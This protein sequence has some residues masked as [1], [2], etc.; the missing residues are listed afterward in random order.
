MS[1]ADCKIYVSKFKNAFAT[2][3]DPF[4]ATLEE[5]AEIIRTTGAASKSQ[6]PWLKLAVFGGQKTDKGSLR[7]DANILEITGIELDY[8]GEQMA[9]DDIIGQLTALGLASL[10]YTSPSHTPGT[11]RWRILCP[12]SASLPPHQRKLL[13]ARLNGR[14][15]GILEG[16]PE[17]F[18][19]SQ[20]YYYGR[21]LDNLRADHKVEVLHGD[22]IDLRED[23]REFETAGMPKETVEE[24]ERV[25]PQLEDDDEPEE[26]RH[27]VFRG[28]FDFI[29]DKMGDGEGLNGFNAPLRAAIAHYVGAFSSFGFDQVMRE[30]LK[31]LLRMK[32]VAAPK[33]ANRPMAEIVD[34]MSD[35]SLD[36]DIS[37]F[38]RVRMKKDITVFDFVANL[39]S[40]KYIYEPTGEE[41]PRISVDFRLK[42][43]PLVD[44]DGRLSYRKN[45]KIKCVKSSTWLQAYRKIE[46]LSWWP[47][48]PKIMKNLWLTQ[49]G[50][51]VEK[52]GH[53]CYNLYLAPAECKGDV[54]KAK[55]WI[56]HVHHIFPDD[57][58]IILDWF[59]HRFQKP[60]EKINFALLLGSIS[61]IG[62]D[63]IIT[64]AGNGLGAGNF[65]TI[66]PRVVI[67]SRFTGYYRSVLLCINEIFDVGEGNR[68]KF[69]EMM[70]QLCASP[71]ETLQVNL[72]MKQEF[73]VR[74]CCGVVMTTNH[75]EGIYLPADDRRTYV[76]W[77]NL[78]VTDFDK[79][80]F[81]TLWN[82]INDGGH[83][84]IWAY[85][86][87]RDITL[88]KAK[89]P[90][91]KTQVHR[92][93]IN[94]NMNPETEELEDL[95]DRNHLDAVTVG[96]VKSLA[97]PELAEWLADRKNAVRI[98][99]RFND[100][101]FSRADNPDHKRG[102]WN[103]HTTGTRVYVRDSIGSTFLPL[104]RE[105]L[106]TNIAKKLAED[107]NSEKQPGSATI[108][109][110]SRPPTKN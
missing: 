105:R 88:F 64:P 5:L 60:D 72:K 77:S 108:H 68:Y 104:E 16:H 73:W 94:A 49:N 37:R 17:S 62:K 83:Q 10:V 44:G 22:F 25:D 50:H 54:T 61:G 75:R 27:R 95:L 26:D 99:H 4:E 42:P 76:C 106:R 71:P 81:P 23:L 11:P 47:G 13:V 102:L 34:Y 69:Y 48:K 56:D 96:L 98:N 74:N 57:A 58:D 12:T 35:K 21:A 38:I 36:R 39:A 78:Q 18:V 2:T 19:L 79:S 8:D 93:I 86:R 92:N 24:D 107:L 90:P 15:G 65:S 97:S 1:S 6:L 28:Q 87:S 110:F 33:R 43:I 70:K 91:L 103:V 89:E 29:L 14:L 3:N 9:F 32:I 66:S 82:W 84:H 41:W 101:G 46:Q 53:D 85:L 100:V 67:E 52:S 55:P 59:A 20:C 31:A 51:M 7:H 40:Q 63:T 45:G 30:K 80:Y 109:P